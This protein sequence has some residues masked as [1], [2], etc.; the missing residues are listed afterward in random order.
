MNAIL[1]KVTANRSNYCHAI[2]VS[3]VY[4]LK[5][6]IETLYGEFEN[7]FTVEEIKEFFSSMSIIA[8]DSHDDSDQNEYEF[9]EEEINDFNT[10]NFIDEL[11]Y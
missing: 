6:V 10:D 3:T 9:E 2:E 4:E 8:F 7:E 1:N 5:I 11:T